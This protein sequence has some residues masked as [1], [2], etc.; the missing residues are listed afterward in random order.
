[1]K[2]LI[3]TTLDETQ[4]IAEAFTSLVRKGDIIA[5]QGTLGAGKTAFTRFFIQKA[6]HSAQDV[7][8]PTFTLLQIYEADEL[9]IYHFDLYRLEKPEDVFELGIED[10]FAQGVNFIEWPD[11]MGKFFPHRKALIIQI[12][13]QSEKRIFTFSSLNP[14]WIERLSSWNV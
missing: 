10:T 6:T 3:A 7:P 4:K 1:M 13:V 12:D 9:P 5:L 2:Q 11:K 14:S 8:S